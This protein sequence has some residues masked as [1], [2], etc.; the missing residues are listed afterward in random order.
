MEQATFHTA[1]REA[2]LQGVDDAPR[3]AARLRSA[4]V[5][6]ICAASL[7]LASGSGSPRR[8]ATSS[9]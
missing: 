1:L 4:V 6:S 9:E 5:A 8:R 2:G 3:E 7:D